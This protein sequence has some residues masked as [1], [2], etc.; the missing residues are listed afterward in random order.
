M[1]RCDTWWR[2]YKDLRRHKKDNLEEGGGSKGVLQGVKRITPTK[3]KI[4]IGG[5]TIM[6]KGA[7]NTILL[8]LIFLM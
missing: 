2:D 8:D 1:K 6:M 7:T 3:R 5:C 4:K